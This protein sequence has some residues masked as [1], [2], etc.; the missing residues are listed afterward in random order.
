MYVVRFEIIFIKNDVELTRLCVM[1]CLLEQL[2]FLTYDNIQEIVNVDERNEIILRLREWRNFDPYYVSTLLRA[3]KIQLLKLPCIDRSLICNECNVEYD[4]DISNRR[5][6][7]DFCHCF[8]CVQEHGCCR[9][10]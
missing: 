7:F 2:S 5:V 8:W 10:D 9:T 1:E 3:D 4:G 6:C